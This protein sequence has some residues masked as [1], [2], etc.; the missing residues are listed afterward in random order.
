MRDDTDSLAPT[1]AV[2]RA[3]SLLVI[4]LSP[5]SEERAGHYNADP[6]FL[7]VR[8]DERRPNFPSSRR[9][10]FIIQVYSESAS[11]RLALKLHTLDEH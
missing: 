6:T 4:S 11:K 8:G 1:Y 10:R 9:L 2:H 5:T 3:T 7:E